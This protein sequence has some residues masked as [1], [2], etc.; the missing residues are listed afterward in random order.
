VVA[1]LLARLHVA[2]NVIEPLL[3]VF[4][5]E[6]VSLR[7]MHAPRAMLDSLPDAI[8]RMPISTHRVEAGQW[9]VGRTVA[10]INLRATTGASVL[11]IGRGSRSIAA[12]S[13]DERLA[14]ADILYLIG[15]DSDVLLARQ[16]LSTGH[17]A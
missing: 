15:D 16:L 11:A 13:A 4:R 5:R 1:Q 3:D 8:R 14:E 17:A 9:A 6:L 7:P 2:G 12:P 10:E